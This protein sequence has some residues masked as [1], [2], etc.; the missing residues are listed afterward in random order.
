MRAASFV[1][2]NAICVY[3]PDCNSLHRNNL[4]DPPKNTTLQNSKNPE[5]QEAFGNIVEDHDFKIRTRGT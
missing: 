2:L 1:T 3:S 5:R 4:R